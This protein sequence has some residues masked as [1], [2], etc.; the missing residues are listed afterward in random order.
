MDYTSQKGKTIILK[1]A[2]RVRQISIEDIV[3]ITCD[4]YLLSIYLAE[5]KEPEIVSKSLKEIERELAN[6]HFLRISRN[7]L[8]NLKYFKSYHINGARR[9]TMFNGDT[10]PVSRRKWSEIKNYF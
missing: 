9:I 3:H 4:S 10:L 5:Q 6:F 1:S 8:I 2:R 7:R